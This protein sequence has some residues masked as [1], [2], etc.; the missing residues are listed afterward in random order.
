MKLPVPAPSRDPRFAPVAAS[1]CRPLKLTAGPLTSAHRAECIKPDI[2][3]CQE[4]TSNLCPDLLRSRNRHFAD[5]EISTL[6]T[7]SYCDIPV[8]KLFSKVISFQD[9]LF[10]LDISCR[11][12][13]ITFSTYRKTVSL[14]LQNVPY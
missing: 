10:Y 7:P 1:C 5:V 9:T 2:A 3:P 8:L 14:V 6:S 13:F 11:T 4:D 12:L